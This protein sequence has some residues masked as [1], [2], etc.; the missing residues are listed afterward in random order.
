MHRNCSSMDQLYEEVEE[1]VSPA[2]QYFNSSVICSYVFGFLEIEIPIDDSM[3]IPLIKDVFLPINP[4]FSSIMIRDENGKRRWKRVEVKPEEHVK[5]PKFPESELYD[6]YFDEYVTRILTERTP[7]NKP[8][9]EIHIIKY[10]TSKAA[11]TVIFKLHHALG[12]GYSLMGALLSCLERIDDPSLPLTFPSRTSSTSQAS[13]K[14]VI[15]KLPSFVSSFFSSLSDFGSSLVKTRMV[16]DD[17]TPVRSGYEG[18]E[19]MLFVLSSI[20]LSVDHVKAI[21]TKL[22]VT[23]NDV[24]TGMIFYGIRL[25]MEEIEY[26]ARKAKST[27]VVMLNTRNVKGYKSVKE[28]QNSKVKGLWGN[29][30]SFLQIPIPKLS[31]SKSYNPLEFVWN[32]RKLIK[33]K[34]RS[35]SV[36]LIGLL[37]DLEM[38]LKGPEAVAK[39]IYK[40]LGNCSVVISNIFGP[41]EQMALANHPISGLYFTM[42]GGPENIDITIMSY[43]KV[44]RITFRTLKGFIDEQKF[45]FCIEKAFDVIFKAAMEISQ[46]PNNK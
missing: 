1:P 46:T 14:N 41:L 6:Q 31:Q 24:I 3:T 32:A 9:W 16:V 19:S 27:A 37:L 25:Y 7:Q 42:T 15:Q 34:R 18:T 29:K 45:R 43:V 21:K 30:I 40:T 33:K 26:M 39:I 8:L 10:P 38:K 12:D 11:G 23:I 13:K 4:R 22:G 36:Y 5:I 35:F 28:M 44:L 20:S 2:G 17:K